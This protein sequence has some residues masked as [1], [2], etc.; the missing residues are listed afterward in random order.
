MYWYFLVA[1]VLLGQIADEMSY[2]ASVVTYADGQFGFC[3]IWGG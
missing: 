2:V 1:S 3:G